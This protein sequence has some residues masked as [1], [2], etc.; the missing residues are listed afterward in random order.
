MNNEE[1]I[2]VEA[3][4][5][6]EL[7]KQRLTVAEISAIV[8]MCDA[9]IYRLMKKAGMHE[10][11]SLLS[12]KKILRRHEKDIRALFESGVPYREIAKKYNVTY[13]I[14]QNWRAALKLPPG[15]RG[16]ANN[17]RVDN[18]KAAELYGRGLKIAEIAGQLGVTKA[19][20][21]YSL[22]KTGVYMGGRQWK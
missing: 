14:V 6:M 2:R 11:F 5:I 20:V 19:A 8:H 18:A 22:K 21:I 4:K 13:K 7:R 16:G 15:R 10:E 9:N 1:E 3:E 17:C 12:P